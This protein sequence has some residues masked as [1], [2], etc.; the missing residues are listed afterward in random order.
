MQES[1]S[2]GDSKEL[3]LPEEWCTD[4]PHM[5]SKKCLEPRKTSRT[6]NNVED[7]RFRINDEVLT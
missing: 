7:F 5:D 1:H 6:R 3:A 4:D 2:H